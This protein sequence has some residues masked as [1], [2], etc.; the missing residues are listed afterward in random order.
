MSLS[1]CLC[2][3][4]RFF[5]ISLCIT[6]CISAQLP[7]LRQL[8]GVDGCIA[9]RRRHARRGDLYGDT[10]LL[11]LNH[12]VGDAAHAPQLLQRARINLVRAHRCRY[13]PRPL[14]CGFILPSPRTLIFAPLVI[15]TLVDVVQTNIRVVSCVRCGALLSKGFQCA[16]LNS[17][18]VH[19]CRDTRLRSGGAKRRKRR[20]C[21]RS[22]WWRLRRR[23]GW[24][25]RHRKARTPQLCQ[26]IS[27]NALNAHRGRDARL[28]RRQRLR[29]RS[30]VPTPSNGWLH[31]HQL[32]RR[33]IILAHAK[34]TSTL[35]IALIT[36]LLPKRSVHLL[37]PFT[38]LENI[39]P[40][41]RSVVIQ[42]Q[43][44]CTK[45]TRLARIYGVRIA[46][47]PH[48]AQRVERD[49]VPSTLALV[50]LDRRLRAGEIDATEK[51]AARPRGALVEEVVGADGEVA[52][53]PRAAL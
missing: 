29:R 13:T 10:C 50:R 53:L 27:I 46:V 21:R 14:R 42:A 33:A 24:C 7:E 2:A 8:A 5:L 49:A 31:L 18:N 51:F 37:Q 26:R 15:V 39:R 11:L 12:R 43:L 30:I 20:R 6:V 44:E 36:A 16:E 1:F 34:L 28:R 38:P 19:C 52:R 32:T 22:C 3:A 17:S 9:H 45:L 48:N 25:W 40:H 41:R 4:L 23:V 35:A 47:K